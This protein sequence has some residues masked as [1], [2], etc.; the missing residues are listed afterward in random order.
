M[1]HRTLGR[2][3]VAACALGL[4]LVGSPALAQELQWQPTIGFGGVYTEDAWT[5]IFVDLANSGPS[6]SG[7]IRSEGRAAC[8]T[9][10][11]PAAGWSSSG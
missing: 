3:P 10:T 7:E 6:V 9:G 2:L 11:S 5:P 1:K 8:S 4:L